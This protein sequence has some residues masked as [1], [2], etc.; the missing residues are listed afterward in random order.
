MLFF[1]Y[2]FADRI[3][4][5]KLNHSK[6]FYFSIMIALTILCVVQVVQYCLQQELQENR[7][8]Y[9]SGW[10]LLSLSSGLGSFYAF[11]KTFHRKK[12]P[13][14]GEVYHL[15]TVAAAPVVARKYK[16][17]FRVAW[18][19]LSHRQKA[20]AR[21]MAICLLWG[22]A[23]LFLIT[24]WQV[25]KAPQPLPQYKTI[26]VI[27]LSIG[28][29]L[30]TITGAGLALDRVWAGPVGYIFSFLQMIWF[31]VGLLT[32]SLL[33]ILLKYVA[34]E[35]IRFRLK[36]DQYMKFTRQKKQSFASKR[37]VNNNL[38]FDANKKDVV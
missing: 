35:P 37:Q 27:Y 1:Y 12:S 36:R 7:I 34:R 5:M 30:I 20:L 33:M 24:L 9:L 19:K 32:G 4:G 25:W 38:S 21:S 18:R 28:L 8:F 6:R 23:T 29:G 3:L 2:S 26:E 16:S 13:S 10:I 14:F 15:T 31:P 17:V 11:K 22:V